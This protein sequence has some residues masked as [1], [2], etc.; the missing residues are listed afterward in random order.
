M[1]D[2]EPFEFTD[3]IEISIPSCPFSIDF[4][5]ELSE[6]EG[7]IKDLKE[8]TDK[9]KG[10]TWNIISNWEKEKQR[11]WGCQLYSLGNAINRYFLLGNIKNLGPI[12]GTIKQ[13]SRR[14]LENKESKNPISMRQHFIEAGSIVGEQLSLEEFQTTVS[15]YHDEINITL[16]ES[17]S[18]AD[19]IDNIK[20]AIN[21]NMTPIVHFD[22]NRQTY[23]PEKNKWDN[24]HT[25]LVVGY[26]TAGKETFFILDS[27]FRYQCV[28]AQTLYQS[29]NQPQPSQYMRESFSKWR[30][31]RK[32]KNNSCWFPNSFEPNPSKSQQ[33][34]NH[35]DYVYPREVMTCKGATFG[36]Q[37]VLVN[38]KKQKQSE[39]KNQSSTTT[40]N[41]ETKSSADQSLTSTQST[42]STTIESTGFKL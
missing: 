6:I 38:L 8:N 21:E 13:S 5:A 31:V 41:S 23:A 15:K 29:S 20:N 16:K 17:K 10:E 11:G 3:E 2:R 30:D 19:Y 40:S 36:T 27:S 9:T 4:K 42:S 32:N 12:R 28:N 35:I 14:A 39:S 25:E 37:L 33:N 7:K 22:A 18:L 24:C 1:L 26:F 34:Y